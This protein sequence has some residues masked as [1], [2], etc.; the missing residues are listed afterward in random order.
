MRPKPRTAGF[1]LIEVL[2]VVA[3]IALLIAILLPSLKR[4]R[5]QARASVCSSNIKQSL[6]GVVLDQA[7]KQM[8]RERWGTNFGWATQ[9]LRGNKGMTGIY[10]CPSDDNPRPIPAV[11]VEQ[12]DGALGSSRYRGTSSGCGIFNRIYRKTGSSWE[13]DVEDQLDDK[14]FGGDAFGD[15]D[16]DLIFSYQASSTQVTSTPTQCSVGG[17]SWHFNV[18]TYD[19]KLLWRDAGRGSGTARMPIMWM[20]YSGNAEAGLKNVKGNPIL[21]VE[22]GKFGIFPRSLPNGYPADNLSKALRFRHDGRDPHPGL[23]GLDY[24]QNRFGAPS[25]SQIDKSYTPCVKLNAGFVDGHVERLA[26]PSLF[27]FNS[28]NV[29]MAPRIK[30]AVWGIRKEGGDLSY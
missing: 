27:T 4:V 15:N 29:N 28:A 30:P 3:I 9:S 26:W 23:R 7:D 13:T 22:G 25:T 18:L 12:W 5:D 20:S 19:G 8:R 16:G 6:T 24:T 21:I 17:A 1:T 2:V 14:V 11:Q 10:T